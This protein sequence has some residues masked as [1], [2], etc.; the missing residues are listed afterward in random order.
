M[1]CG[2]ELSSSW[3]AESYA[4]T[5]G[6]GMGELTLGMKKAP[7]LWIPGEECLL[8]SSLERAAGI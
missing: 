6:I 7:S 3:E 1:T 5:E 8:E 4:R 2:V